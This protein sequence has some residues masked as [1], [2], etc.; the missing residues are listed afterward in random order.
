M[1]LVGAISSIASIGILYN[2]AVEAEKSRLVSLVSSKAR[3][4]NAIAVF[5][6]QYSRVDHPEG[7][8]GATLS[9]VKNSFEFKNGFGETGEFVVGTLNGGNIEFLMSS[10]ALNQTPQPIA[11]ND[12]A[13]EPMRRALNNQSG[14]II[15][16]DYQSQR[17]LAAYQ[18]IPFLNIGIVAKIDMAEVQEPF[19][20][21]SVNALLIAVFIIVLGTLL[22][23]QIEDEDHSA[24]E[25]FA[26]TSGTSTKEWLI[27]RSLLLAAVSISVM[28]SSIGLLYQYA[29]DAERQSLL[30]M[31]ETQASLINAV[32]DF[33]AKYNDDDFPGGAVGATLKQVSTALQESPG[34]GES[35]EYLIGSFNKYEIIYLTQPRNAKGTDIS[36]HVAEPRSNAMKQALAGRTGMMPDIDYRNISVLAAYTPIPRLKAGLVAKIDVEEMRQ[37]FIKA[38]SQAG[39]VS[40]VAIGFGALFLWHLSQSYKNR[41]RVETDRLISRGL[42]MVEESKVTVVLVLFTLSLGVA[43]FSLDILLPL[44]VACGLPYIFFVLTGKLFPRREYTLGLAIIASILVYVGYH[45]SPEGGQDWVVITNRLLAVVAIW[46]TALTVS[47]S[48]AQNRAQ[49]IQASELR[50]LSLAVEHSPVSVIITDPNGMIQYVNQKYTELTGFSREESVGHKSN[51]TRSGNTP[52]KQYQDLWETLKNGK[53]WQGEFQNR[54]KSG[55]LYWERS[56][57][58]PIITGSGKIVNYVA[59]QEDITQRKEHERKLRYHATHDTLTG[60]PTRSLCMDRLHKVLD[61]AKRNHQQAAV[62][63]IDLDGF[64]EV[65]DNFGHDVGDK[66]L[67][68]TAARLKSSVRESDTVA[69]IGGDEFII[70]LS[71]ISQPNDASK[72]AQTVLDRIKNSYLYD[73]RDEEIHIGVS[74]GISLYPDNALDPEALIQF[75]DKAMY[76][77]KTEGKNNFSFAEMDL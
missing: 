1:M 64:K 7:A 58:H 30:D 2:S 77:V 15:D 50:R 66:V 38:A 35:G 68:E 51:M 25:T 3:L 33:D 45:F 6:S 72:V 76:C 10:R 21:A 59:L 60:L 56:S 5:D 67:I 42:S 71:E 55:E 12:S 49:K 65:N 53:E 23:S 63:F 31:V 62:L 73:D 13:A 69:R 27:Y 29:R 19:I 34:F 75:A 22:I 43:L 14:T 41:Q 39:A 32:A 61:L 54:K 46:L 16:L 57:I 47:L 74:I 18:S 8:V 28:I 20:D 11:I 52:T 44:G 9:Q 4:I 40:I 26:L 36:F 70:L 17:V 24:R 37:P 48:Q